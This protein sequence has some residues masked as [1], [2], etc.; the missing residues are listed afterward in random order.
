M[1]GHCEH[2]GVQAGHVPGCVAELAAALEAKRIEAVAYLRSRGI[3][4]AD[5]ACRHQ[6]EPRPRGSIERPAVVTVYNAP[7]A[8]FQRTLRG[9]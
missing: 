7:A 6:Y 2:C 1:S 3:Y 9:A 8:A 4:R 5:T